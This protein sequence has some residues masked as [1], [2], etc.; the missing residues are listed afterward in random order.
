MYNCVENS[1]KN[2][3]FPVCQI[4]SEMHSTVAIHSWLMEW[5]K[6][7]VPYPREIVCESSRALLTATVRN[8][9]I[10]RTVE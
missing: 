4:L 3:L 5:S 1:V 6:S 10:F 8:F 7:G 9:S 2:G